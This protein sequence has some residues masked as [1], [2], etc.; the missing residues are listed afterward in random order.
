MKSD[1]FSH[2]V[3]H[4]LRAPLRAM[5][6]FAEIL[7][8]ELRDVLGERGRDYVGRIHDAARQLSQMIE[9]LLQLGRLTEAELACKPLAPERALDWA[10]ADEDLSVESPLPLVT[11]HEPTLILVFEHLLA[12]AR[13]FVAPGVRPKVRVRGEARGEAARIW[14]EDNGVGIPPEHAARIFGVFVRLHPKYPGTGI[15]LAIVAR[16][17]ERMGGRAGV[18][19]GPEGGS[20]FWI[21]LPRG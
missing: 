6:G 17:V 19:P 12:N 1:V 8:E 10:R 18:E 21:E 5:T 20:R 15:G 16:A 14:I 7:R 9:G 11:A 3:A 2:S 4:D 13:T